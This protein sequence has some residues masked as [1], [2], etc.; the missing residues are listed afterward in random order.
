MLP[1]AW[2]D[3]IKLHKIFVNQKLIANITGD[4]ISQHST[5]LCGIY[6]QLSVSSSTALTG[7]MLTSVT[8]LNSGHCSRNFSST[9]ARTFVPSRFSSVK[10]GK[11]RHK[12]PATES[13]PQFYFTVM[14]I[15]WQYMQSLHKRSI[16]SCIKMSCHLELNFSSD[17]DESR[18]LCR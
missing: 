8:R 3:C 5:N 1:V 10:Y 13:L 17:L 12:A 2:I 15:W 4:I 6:Y 11:L 7:S 14:N 18:I 16:W 9:S